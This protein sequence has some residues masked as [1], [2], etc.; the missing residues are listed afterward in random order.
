MNYKERVDE[1][2]QIRV[3]WDRI[4]PPQTLATLDV[5]ESSRLPR[6]HQRTFAPQLVCRTG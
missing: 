2:R 6:T 5:H 1:K 4:M 3:F